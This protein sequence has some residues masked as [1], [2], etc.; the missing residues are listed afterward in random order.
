MSV[1]KPRTAP[2]ASSR[3][4]AA[5]RSCHSCCGLSGSHGALSSMRNAAGASKQVSSAAECEFQ[6]ATPRRCGARLTGRW[7]A[8]GPAATH[9]RR[10]ARTHL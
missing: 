1:K 3:D 4:A 5:S 6:R 10:G 2:L 8:L 9:L 7:S